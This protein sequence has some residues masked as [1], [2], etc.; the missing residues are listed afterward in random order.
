MEGEAWSEN[1]TAGARTDPGHLP[2][3]AARGRV[4]A[5]PEERHA[6]QRPAAAAVGRQRRAR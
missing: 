2:A 5:D 4:A 6:W 3:A 1:T